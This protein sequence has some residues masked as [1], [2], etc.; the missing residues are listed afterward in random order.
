MKFRI[1]HRT[2]SRTVQLDGDESELTLSHLLAAVSNTFSDILTGSFYLSLNKKDCLGDDD[3]TLKSLGLV[4]GDLVHL[5][6]TDPDNVQEI[7]QP[8]SGQ[9]SNRPLGL[10]DLATSSSSTSEQPSTSIPGQQL[11]QTSTSKYIDEMEA[12]HFQSGAMNFQSE[13]VNP[14]DQAVVTQCLS[15]PRLCCESTPGRL[16]ALLTELY[17]DAQCRFYEEA[18][19]LVLHVLMLE[20]GYQPSIPNSVS[21]STDTQTDTDGMGC[22]PERSQGSDLG[23]GSDF[24]PTPS[25]RRQAPAFYC[26]E[27]T[28]PSSGPTVYTV[29]AVPMGASLV[30]HGLVKIDEN[31]DKCKCQIKTKDFVQELAPEAGACYQ[32]LPQVSRIFKD[33]ICLPLQQKYR[34]AMNL[35]PLHGIQALSNELK[36]KILGHLDVLSLLT[37]SQVCKE[38]HGLSNDRFIWRRLFLYHFGNRAQN[39]LNQNWKELY[40]AEYRIRKQH[41][42]WLSQMTT[43][44]PPFIPAD[45]YTQRVPPLAPFSPGMIGGDYDLYLQFHGVPNP[46]FGRRGGRFPDL[47]PRFYPFG[48]GQNFPPGPG[49]GFQDGQRGGSRLQGGSRSGNSWLGGGPRWF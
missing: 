22:G 25:W 14:L 48:P 31:V 32:N 37:M 44:V 38:F 4:S 43:L 16:P 46:L 36:L 9:Q 6:S 27:Y 2:V 41:R 47:R 12:E 23:Q 24:S 5:V 39:V 34:E 7:Q 8:A 18:L 29:T 40:K 11:G 19:C 15:E 26:L 20:A 17:S 45:P 13:A 10:P 49:G 42:K 35:V 21:S 1:K 30:V 28:H 3:Q 33:A